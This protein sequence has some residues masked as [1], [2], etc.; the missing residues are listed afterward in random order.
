MCRLMY[1]FFSVVATVVAV[2]FGV[3]A[4]DYKLEIKDFD[5]L[6]V[7]DGINVEYHCSTDSAGWAYFSCAPEL[8]SKLLFTNNK[9]K[10]HIQVDLTD[11]VIN[12]LPT[13]H[14]YSSS[15]KKVENSSDS[16]VTVVSNVVIPSLN[17][18][19]IGNGAVI[20]NNIQAGAVNATINTGKGHIVI[21]GTAGTAKYTNV[22]TGTIEAGGLN[23][24]NVKVHVLGTGSIDCT[25]TK[26]LS[27]YG[28]GS[29]KVY[30]AGNPENVTN[31]SLGV[32]ATSM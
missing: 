5:E 7:T 13:L 28:A 27:I 6:N 26:S 17:V 15:L 20:V 24:P 3:C 1:R 16:T 22:G 8:S 12:D 23:V 29:G 14:V 31:R 9:S 10:L 4:N 21:S 30:Y 19:V 25:A 32:K 2:A 18:K 11:G